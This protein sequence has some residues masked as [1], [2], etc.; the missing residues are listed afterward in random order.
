MSDPE[1]AFNM[2]PL[3]CPDC[4]GILHHVMIPDPPNHWV[5]FVKFLTAGVVGWC[6]YWLATH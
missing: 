5:I 4:G 1:G 2:S 3:V 6:V